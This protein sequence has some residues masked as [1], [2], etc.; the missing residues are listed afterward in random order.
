MTIEK[1]FYL[2]AQ[3]VFMLYIFIYRNSFVPLCL[4]P[5]PD[6][7]PNVVIQ[8]EMIDRRQLETLESPV[9]TI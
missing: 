8:R 4:H 2:D 7:G 3:C 1:D 5:A 6:A 9:T